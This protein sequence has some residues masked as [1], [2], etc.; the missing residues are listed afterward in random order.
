MEPT[1]EIT[2]LLVAARGGDTTALGRVFSLVHSELREAAHRQLARGRPGETLNTTA[3]VHE[4]FLKLAGSNAAFD[5]RRHFLAVAATAM[6]QLV[7]DYARER[8]A[9]KRGGGAAHLSFD[10]SGIASPERSDEV[11]ALDEALTALG[12][13]SAR[14]VQVVELRF[15]VGLSVEETAEVMKLS[16]RSVKRD[17]QKARAWLYR[18]LH[19]DG[20]AAAGPT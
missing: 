20:P 10:G 7:V 12:S 9:Q 18:A 14:L 19:A 1:G 4:A 8:G 13:L 5:D 15:F 16:P 2:R 11:L 17:W 3:L 6:R